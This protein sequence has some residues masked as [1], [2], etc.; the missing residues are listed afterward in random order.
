MYWDLVYAYENARVQKESLAFADKTL[1]DTKKQV[2]I[3]S[4]AP[5][6]VVRAQSTVA[7]DQQALTIA[8]TNLQL[9]QLLMK[10]ALSRTLQDPDL[11]RAEVI[12]TSTMDVA[13]ERSGTYLR[14]DLINDALRHRA[15]LVEPRIQLNSPSSATRRSV[16]RY[17]RRST[18]LPT[19]VGREWAAIR[20]HWQYLCPRV[21]LPAIRLRNGTGHASRDIP[22][23]PH[24][25]HSE[26][27]GQFHEP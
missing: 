18:C 4:L 10:N 2:E 9:E 12:P 24:R 21:L 7:Q 27:A 15:E 5:I 13:R 26:S 19:T 14:E 8:L 6:E 22:V 20:I 25:V 3:G 1:S 23:D 16:A 17:C 11:A